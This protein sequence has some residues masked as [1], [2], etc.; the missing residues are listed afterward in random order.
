MPRT[1]SHAELDE[2]AELDDGN[3]IELGDQ[4]RQLSCKLVKF[5]V[6]GGYYGTDHRHFEE[7]CKPFVTQY[8]S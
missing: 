5:K 3:S 4:H 7:F 1:Q 2:A 6:L 8:E